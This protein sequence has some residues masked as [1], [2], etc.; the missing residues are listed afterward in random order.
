MAYQQNIHRK[1]IQ[2][3]FLRHCT[4]NNQKRIKLLNI[5]NKKIIYP[6]KIGVDKCWKQGYYAVSAAVNTHRP[7]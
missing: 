2:K 4:E 5:N 1:T 3:Y 6:K 7:G